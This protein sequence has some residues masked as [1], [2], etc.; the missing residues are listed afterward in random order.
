MVG[1][2]RLLLMGAGHAHAQVLKDWITAPVQG[3]ELVVV[4]PSALAPYSGM[5]P[6]WLA[7][8]YQ[9]DEICI[10]L[11]ALTAAAG[12]RLV[13]DEMTSLDPVRQCVQLASGDILSYDVLSLNVG[14]TL[15]AP[16]NTN[17]PVLSLRPLGNLR[18]SWESVLHDLTVSAVDTPLKITSIG[19][20]AAGVEA[21]LATLA[22]LRSLQPRRTI[23]GN[24]ITRSAALLPGM[25]ASAVR[26]AHAALTQA[27]VTVQLNTEYSD[28]VASA[29]DLLLWA[30]G[31]EAHAWQRNCGLAVSARGFISIDKHL[32]STSHPQIYAV[33]D[34]A[35]WAQPLPKA[36]VY[37]VRMG[38]VLSN[39]LRA[40][41]DVGTAMSYEPQHR[42]LALLNTANHTGNHNDNNSAIASWGNWSARGH[43]VWRWKDHI[44]RAF[45]KRFNNID[46]ALT[47]TPPNQ[48]K[49]SK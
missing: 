44:D 29:A 23:S 35:E 48:F 39:N 8:Q 27:H 42:F 20:G 11:K 6:G 32:R 49:P 41:L 31:A 2:K 28:S 17:V 38:P 34:C 15:N 13:I 46:H 18:I 1:M 30:T 26:S 43:W 4:S 33:G 9:Y 21:L 25:A 19:G 37:A 12:A 40:A 5:V 10:Q 24:L 14:S 16:L 47:A 45:L 7:G 22:R 36:G 3:A